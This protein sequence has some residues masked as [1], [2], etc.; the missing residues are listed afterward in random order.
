MVVFS[1]GFEA[2]DFSA[3]T[4]TNGAPTVQHTHVFAGTHAMQVTA[5]NEYAR[6]AVADCDTLY[7]RT[8]FRLNAVPAGADYLNIVRI[9]S[10]V[11]NEILMIQVMDGLLMFISGYPPGGDSVAV[12]WQT[13]VWYSVKAKLVRNNGAGEYRV[14]LNNVEVMNST[15]LDSS[16][17]PV[18]FYCMV[19]NYSLVGG[20]YTLQHDNVVVDTA[21]I[22]EEAIASAALEPGW[23]PE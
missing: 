16:A 8:M 4:G 2:G 15:G 6:I 11:W 20:H 3:W 13:G 21:D 17:M 18:G 22:D 5:D 7:M 12:D 19:G 9:T 14:W 10:N 1:D 23:W